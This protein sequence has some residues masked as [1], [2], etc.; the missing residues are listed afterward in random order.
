MNPNMETTANLARDN[1]R[2]TMSTTVLESS[3]KRSHMEADDVELRGDQQLALT[4][5]HDETFLHAE[6]SELEHQVNRSSR[7]TYLG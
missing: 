2:K 7:Q 1:K 5:I 4:K 3:N 6:I